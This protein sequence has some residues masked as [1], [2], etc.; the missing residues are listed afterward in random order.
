MVDW[1]WRLCNIA[2]ENGGVILYKGKGERMEYNFY[3]GIRDSVLKVTEGL[4]DDEQAR[5]K[6]L[7][8]VGVMDLEKAYDRVNRKV[9]WQLLR[10]YDVDGKLLNSIKSMYVNSL[11]CVE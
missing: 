1:I 3:K 6:N 4:I 5:G 7:V 11:A 8:Y 10:M 2:F 9:L